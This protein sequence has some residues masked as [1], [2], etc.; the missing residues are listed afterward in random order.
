[1]LGDLPMLSAHK[2]HAANAVEL[3]VFRFPTT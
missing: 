1:V 3:T 2:A